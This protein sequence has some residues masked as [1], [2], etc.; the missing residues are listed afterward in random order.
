MDDNKIIWKAKLHQILDRGD[1]TTH[2][3][4][5]SPTVAVFHPQV[6]SWIPA[7]NNL[8][9]Q[10]DVCILHFISESYNRWFLLLQT[11]NFS[12]F[13]I[14]FPS[15]AKCIWPPRDQ[16]REHIEWGVHLV[17]LQMPVS[18]DEKVES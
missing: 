17:E 3:T 2:L 13:H 9:L 7:N 16:D 1:K 15:T 4:V 14:I 5:L 18:K 8:Q 12:N 11:I 10:R 6:K